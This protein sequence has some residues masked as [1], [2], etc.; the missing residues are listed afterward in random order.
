MGAGMATHINI[1]TTLS[2]AYGLTLA[3]GTEADDV[4]DTSTVEAAELVSQSTGEVTK[5]T[6]VNVNRREVTVSGEGPH[7]LTAAAV[8]TVADPS[9]LTITKAEVSEAPNARC[10]FALTLVGHEDFTDPAST[11]SATGAEPTIA[12]LE[13]TSV[14][15]SIA[16]RVSRSYEVQDLVLIGT[17]GTPAA[18]HRVGLVGSVSIAG[19][20]D[21]PAGAALG[22]GGAAFTGCNTGI[23]MV[24]TQMEGEKRRD[25]N[26]W[27]VEGK[28]YKSAA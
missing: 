9:T 28:H 13:I 24:N 26:R 23:V 10:T 17:N 19:R 8:G 21:L 12:D 11:P 7:A 4:Q 2:S 20:G 1:T 18:R 15:Y 6:P 3:S 25:W 27:S 22:T 5:V 16:E 14:E